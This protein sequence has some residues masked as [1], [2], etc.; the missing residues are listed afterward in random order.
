MPRTLLKSWWLLAACG[1]FEAAIAFVNFLMRDPS[2]SLTLRQFAGVNTVVF[3]GKFALAAGVCA[4]AAVIWMSMKSKA[5]LL[6]LNGLALCVYGL[7]SVFWSQGKLAF[8][9]VALL[10]VVM[11]I[12]LGIYALAVALT[13]GRGPGQWLLG[14]AGAI[15]VGFA[16]A[17]FALG[18]RWIGFHGPGSYFL[19]SSSYFGFSAICMLGLGLR[20]NARLA[21]LHHM[22]S[23][24]SPTL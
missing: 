16:L 17:F 12:S 24:A 19:W 13:Q 6:A 14:L 3:Q 22:A 1:V 18:L 9:P 23:G 21:T 4:L 10:F 20:L 8:L 2:G 5:W 15:S 11:A 7:I